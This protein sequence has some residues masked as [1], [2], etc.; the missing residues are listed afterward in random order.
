M[1]EA[2]VITT[3][4]GVLEIIEQLRTRTDARIEVESDFTKG[5]KAIF[6]RI[7]GVVFLQDEIAG[8]TAGKVANQ[9]KTLL[10]GEPIRLVLLRESASTWD[11]GC[12]SFDGVIDLTLPTDELVG[13]FLQH[14]DSAPDPDKVSSAGENPLQADS[15]VIELS[16][17]SSQPESE[18][19]FDPFSE[20]FPAHYHHN[21]GTLL[22]E[23]G[24]E[25]A[26]P[27]E[28][29]ALARNSAGPYEE[30]SFDPPGDI[31]S[32]IPLA[33]TAAPQPA[34]KNY[35]PGSQGQA[36][37][38]ETVA[39]AETMPEL[40]D[41]RLTDKESPH[42]LFASMN[43]E[44]P[45]DNQFQHAGS[46]SS[47]ASLEN[48][49]RLKGIQTHS[50]IL[51][52]SAPEIVPTSEATGVAQVASGSTGQ[53]A[54]RRSA[55]QPPSAHA[56]AGNAS[57]KS[58]TA[59]QPRNRLSAEGDINASAAIS[60]EYAVKTSLTHKLG[61]ALLLLV[62]CL[63]TFLLVRNWDDLAG[64]LFKGKKEVSIPQT[65]PPPAMEKLPAFIP[66]GIPDNAYAAA[67]PGWERYE[68]GGLEYLVYRENGRIRAL[69]VI[70]GTEG[71]ISDEFLRMCIRVSTGL[72]D[73]S[74]WIREQRA[75]FRVEKWTLPNKG[76]VAVYRKMPEGEIR[77]FVITLHR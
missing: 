22:S 33:S 73:G 15:Q 67:H 3:I 76:E 42:Q 74:N 39:V 47:P 7:P 24:Q 2:L 48:R 57:A 50:S 9:V 23:A 72:D 12:L 29:A 19:G 31:V 30:F 66:A 75:D 49:L 5:L 17:D 70:A 53:S 69:Q 26:K 10:E 64:V 18:A 40:K 59:P 68:A 38:T 43:D 16:I 46:D 77:G 14:V 52:A 56:A 71:K 65:P 45:A 11:E 41:I 20:I 37:A 54:A 13:L 21:W 28:P 60:D 1:Q 34:A 27:A 25:I 35:P 61:Y 58:G 6:Y 63:A 51:K 8:I 62:L 4:Q 36:S 55:Q 44:A 32:T